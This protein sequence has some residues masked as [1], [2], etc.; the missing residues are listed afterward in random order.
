MQTA[1]PSERA[2]ASGGQLAW[3]NGGR[4]TPAIRILAVASLIVQ[5]ALVMPN[6]YLA[7]RDQS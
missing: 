3:Q 5:V 2:I 4:R 1:S 7:A 6:D